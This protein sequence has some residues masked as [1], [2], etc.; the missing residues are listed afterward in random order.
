MS[1]EILPGSAPSLEVMMAVIREEYPGAKTGIV[2]VFDE[3]GGM[4]THYRCNDREM[5]LAGSRLLHLVHT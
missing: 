1:I 2:I 5:A 4:H 3:D